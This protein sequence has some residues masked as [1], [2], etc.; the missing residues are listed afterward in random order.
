MRKL[1]NELKE[2]EKIRNLQNLDLLFVRCSST[3]IQQEAA[4]IGTRKASEKIKG[5]IMMDSTIDGIKGTIHLKP[6]ELS[7]ADDYDLCLFYEIDQG[8]QCVPRLIEGVTIPE[9]TVNEVDI[10]ETILWHEHRG[11]YPIHPHRVQRKPMGA[12]Q[13][14][15]SVACG[16]APEVIHKGAGSGFTLGRGKAVAVPKYAVREHGGELRP[17]APAMN[18]DQVNSNSCWNQGARCRPLSSSKPWRGGRNFLP[19]SGGFDCS[20][21]E[22]RRLNNPSRGA[23][24]VGW[25]RNH[26]ERSGQ[27][28]PPN[29]SSWGNSGRGR[30]RGWF[31]DRSLT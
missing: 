12:D 10:P 8:C 6:E 19:S 14:F 17:G 7:Q 2:I 9:K 11:S 20:S 24:A 23:P 29:Q 4:C 25:Q 21:R 15:K 16:P 28:Q 18:G 30:G 31:V 3:T 27:V 13:N 22:D 5:A 1:E 26:V